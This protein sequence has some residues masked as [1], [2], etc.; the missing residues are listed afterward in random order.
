MKKQEVLKP[1]KF[2]TCDDDVMSSSYSGNDTLHKK[3]LCL[4]TEGKGNAI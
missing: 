2:L 4:N 1:N 3:G